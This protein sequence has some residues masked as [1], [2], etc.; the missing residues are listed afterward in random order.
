M[1]RVKNA[2][3]E[4]N[5]ITGSDAFT[6]STGS[7]T[8]AAGSLIKGTYAARTNWSASAN[9]NGSITGISSGEWW[10][11]FYIR[12]AAYPASTARIFSTTNGST[13][14][15]F[16]MT[17]AGLVAVRQN[18]TGLGTLATLSLNTTYRIGVHV[19]IASDIAVSDAV[20]DVY[21]TAAGSPDAAFGAAVISNAA[22]T[23]N[24]INNVFTNAV[25]GHSNGAAATGDI[26]W[27]NVRLD[28]VSMPTDDVAGSTDTP[29]T[30][31][32]SVIS[33][34]SIVKGVGLPRSVIATITPVI[35][36][37]IDTVKVITRAVT[38]TVSMQRAIS[39]IKT[40][41]VTDTFIFNKGVV[42]VQVI[43][44]AIT[45][46]PSIIK[47]IGK[48]IIQAVSAVLT[49]NTI[50]PKN[51][52]VS[53]TPILFLQKDWSFTKLITSV[54]NVVVIGGQ[55]YYKAADVVVN[56]SL[57]IRKDILKPIIVIQ[58]VI[59]S[60]ESKNISKVFTTTIIEI[61][62][63]LHNASILRDITVSVSTV[64]DR[65]INVGKT[66]DIIQDTVV[67][68]QRSFTLLITAL[69]TTPV[70]L[71][72]Q[73]RILLVR[74]VIVN[75]FLSF[76]KILPSRYANTPFH[77][78]MRAIAIGFKNSTLTVLGKNARTIQLRDTNHDDN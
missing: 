49:R 68:M 45:T 26:Y 59:A 17:S 51:V 3:F 6:T 5:A 60:L 72:V 22:L 77:K 55:L 50:I 48:P 23:M 28:T 29:M 16:T 31:T 9:V 21:I 39:F 64:I 52:L 78:N 10:A 11:S 75:S 19:K 57:V 44:L 12:V 67:T 20:A 71:T 30:V 13:Q 35:T 54:V 37:A 34:K 69:V 32:V 56:A 58:S 47:D 66:I 61:V 74:D 62:D 27:D 41:A 4:S 14:L 15:N 36:K 40:I 43:T 63:A 8:V 25:F 2:T 18:T 38:S 1:T 33:T 7:P 46:A 76:S 53:V 65:M 73:K 42:T 24:T 70:V